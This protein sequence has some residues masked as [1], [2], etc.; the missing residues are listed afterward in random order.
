MVAKPRRLHLCTFI[1]SFSHLFIY[2]HLQCSRVE[3][4][5]SHV[6]GMNILHQTTPPAQ[7]CAS[8]RYP[9]LPLAFPSWSLLQCNNW[10]FPP[11]SYITTF[12]IFLYCCCPT[13]IFCTLSYEL[14]FPQV[15]PDN[16]PPRSLGITLAHRI[17][18][19]SLFP[20][21]SSKPVLK[22][23][24]LT[25]IFSKGTSPK[26]KVG[27]NKKLLATRVRH[28][29][30]ICVSC[31]LFTLSVCLIPTRAMPLNWVIDTKH[32]VECSKR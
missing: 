20:N 10:L 5:T 11:S 29:G 23:R 8:N 13:C 17:T 19:C 18:A 24:F 3:L 14:H 25:T 2:L 30:H 1:Y 9:V 27:Q 32:C 7:A 16:L 4:R 12:P 31:F 15:F 21:S 22:P 6:L 28:S 26:V